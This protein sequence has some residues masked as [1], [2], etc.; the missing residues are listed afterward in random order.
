MRIGNWILGDRDSRLHGISD[1]EIL[2]VFQLSLGEKKENSLTLVG[3]TGKGSRTWSLEEELRE[4]RGHFFGLVRS[5]YG[6]EML[7]ARK[8][9]LNENR[10]LGLGPPNR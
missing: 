1:K 4:M 10:R 9:A 3:V 6:R 8:M 7:D 2:Q 5:R